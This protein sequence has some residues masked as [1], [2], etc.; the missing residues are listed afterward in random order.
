MSNLVQ[1]FFSFQPNQR[2]GTGV[3]LGIVAIGACAIVELVG[4]S[5]RLR[6]SSSHLE[7][8]EHRLDGRTDPS[9]IA[10]ASGALP[11]AHVAMRRVRA[12]VE[13]HRAGAEIE[14]ESLAA[15]GSA[16]LDREARFTRWAA[17]TVV[18]FG[19]AGTLMG[20]TQAVL[21]AQP[22]LGQIVDGPAAVQA[23]VGTFSGLGTA[24]ATTLMGIFWAVLLGLGLAWFRAR[25]G[26]FLQRLEEVSMVRLYPFFRTSPALAM[27]DAARTLGAL[28]EKLGTALG[29]IVMQLRTQGLALAKTVEDSLSDVVETSKSVGDRLRGSVESSLSEVVRETHEQGVALTSTVDR[30]LSTLIDE[31]RTAIAAMLDRLDA[32]QTTAATLLGSPAEGSRSLAES[33]SA[34]EVGVGALGTAA[35]QLVQITP[36]IEEAIA[37]QVDQQTRDLHETLHAYVG[38]L[39]EAVERQD[40]VIEDGLLKIGQGFPRFGEL[41]LERLRE[42]GQVLAASLETPYQQVAAA[43]RQQSVQLAAFGDAAGQLRDGAALL[44]ERG[45]QDRESSRELGAAVG[46]LG[47]QVEAIGAQLSR[48]EGRFKALEQHLDAFEQR[49][50]PAQPS[51][52]FG[53]AAPAHPRQPV[54]IPDMRPA[55]LTPQ[56]GSPPSSGSAE[57]TGNGRRP[58]PPSSPPDAGPREDGFWDRIFHRG[59]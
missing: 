21:R 17:S 33:L 38:K 22:I 59:K 26:V 14:A 48:L 10:Q 8:F 27:V 15:I 30:S 57:R 45:A 49:V 36:G 9:E 6:A 52:A 18:L 11:Q 24:F 46:Q 13:L 53:Q 25:Q 7:Q 41:I 47:T 3:N 16:E 29:E 58:D 32:T 55:L 54:V 4:A 12:L 43:L 19:L 2:I 42:Q 44:Q 28:E 34:L 5:H 31:Q 40:A 56:S 39:T 23:V 35:E 20:L 51:P 1:F 50:P 37:R